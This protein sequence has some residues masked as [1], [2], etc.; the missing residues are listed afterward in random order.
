TTPAPT[1]TSTLSLHDAL[2]ICIVLK[3]RVPRRPGQPVPLPPPGPLMD[4]QRALSLV[5]SKA[6][7]WG[8]DPHRIGMVGFSA[9][10]HLAL[11]VATDRKSTRL[12][13]SHRTISYAVF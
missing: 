2:P 1:A 4:A 5:R 9:G 3:Y 7:E 13:S 12:N 8:I 6:G 10:G 11:A